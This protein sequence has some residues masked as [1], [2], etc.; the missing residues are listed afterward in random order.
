[1]STPKQAWKNDPNYEQV[2]AERYRLSREWLKPLLT[3]GSW[4][5]S[6]GDPGSFESWAA[7]QIGQGGRLDPYGYDL[8]YAF[9]SQLRNVRYDVALCMEVF[10]HIHDQEEDKPTE[11]RA[12]GTANL[13]REI[14]AHLKPGGLLFLT[15]PNACSLNV[16]FK[17]L[18]MQPPMV[19][20]P[21]VREY[22]PTEIADMLR[23]AGFALKRFETL[24]PWG[25]GCSGSTRRITEKLLRDHGHESPHRGED[26]FVLAQKPSNA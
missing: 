14:F 20:R 12:T 2:H 1:M 7:A 15:T 6:L 5:L 21:H 19:Y 8:R 9:D 22:A 26:I 13:L 24:D 11:W 4:V 16:L 3:P 18:T 17:V 23:G 25:G 10:E